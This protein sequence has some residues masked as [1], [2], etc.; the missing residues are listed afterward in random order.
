VFITIIVL[1]LEDTQLYSEPWVQDTMLLGYAENIRD[2]VTE[3]FLDY[4]EP[5][6]TQIF[7]KGI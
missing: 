1:I 7:K 6:E 2:F 5:L 3:L 4:Y